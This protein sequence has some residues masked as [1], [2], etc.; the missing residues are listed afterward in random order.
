MLEN[1][2]P[3]EARE[4][5]AGLVDPNNTLAPGWAEEQKRKAIEF[6]ASLPE[7]FG[8]TLDRMTLW[9]RI[10][11]A[12]QSAHAKTVG[13]DC[14]FFV[15]RVLDHIQAAPS[16][17][18]RNVSVQFMLDWLAGCSVEARQ[19]WLAY[20]HTH[21]YAVLVNAKAAWEERKLERKDVGHE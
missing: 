20:L 15:S 17:V 18:A 5:I 13:A 6:V 7:V 9:D 19:A 1:L 3:Q 11:T 16:A 10:G 14:E 4:R 2:T 8:D 12:L 21:F